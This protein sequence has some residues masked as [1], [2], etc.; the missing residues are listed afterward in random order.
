MHTPKYKKIFDEKPNTSR[1]TSL[2]DYEG[3]SGVDTQDDTSII[4]QTATATT[5]N[6]DSSKIEGTESIMVRQRQAI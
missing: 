1:M 5:T 6:A 2:L 3:I 4:I